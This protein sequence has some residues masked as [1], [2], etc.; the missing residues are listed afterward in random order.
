MIHIVLK[1]TTA[2]CLWNAQMRSMAPSSMQRKTLWKLH[3]QKHCIFWIA[4]KY[5]EC[6][7]HT[8]VDLL[9][10]ISFW[11]FQ[12]A[13]LCK[14]TVLWILSVPSNCYSGAVRKME[15]LSLFTCI[16][17]PL[18][19]TCHMTKPKCIFLN[20]TIALY[21]SVSWLFY[22]LLY[23]SCVANTLLHTRLDHVS[24]LTK[25][26]LGYIFFSSFKYFT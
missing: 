25:P 17:M 10:R 7:A 21:C 1:K 18:T 11:S 23:G 13:H 3:Q 26:H 6:K 15:I 22:Q 24:L 9:R 5:T 19:L 8:G 16:Y 12:M 4:Y 2:S 14:E 20:E